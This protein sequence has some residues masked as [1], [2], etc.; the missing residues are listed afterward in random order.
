MTKDQIW[1]RL[2]N[3][4]ELLTIATCEVRG[5]SNIE[6]S[7][8]RLY[9]S[10][11]IEEIKKKNRKE[12]EDSARGISRFPLIR[13]ISES[14]ISDSQT[15]SVGSQIPI[16]SPPTSRRLRRERTSLSHVEAPSVTHSQSDIKKTQLSD[17]LS[18]DIVREILL[19]PVGEQTSIGP[20]TEQGTQDHHPSDRLIRDSLDSINERSPKRRKLDDVTSCNATPSTIDREFLDF[21]SEKFREKLFRVI[22][23]SFTP[24]FSSLPFSQFSTIYGYPPKLSDV[25]IQGIIKSKTTF[26]DEQSPCFHLYSRT[27]FDATCV[28]SL[29]QLPTLASLSSS[30]CLATAT[31]PILE[32]LC[33]QTARRYPNRQWLQ[34]A[35][36]SLRMAC[37]QTAI[38]PPPNGSNINLYRKVLFEQAAKHNADPKGIVPSESTALMY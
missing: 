16:S 28:S 15:T 27:P 9:S 35:R 8:N 24:S 33:Q 25:I 2:S 6:S 26:F 12:L 37:S 3:E 5:T 7:R 32:P 17:C 18:C 1:N 36:N 22:Q 20:K 10:P 29:A 4:S 23:Q 21:P 30:S 19:T 31:C 14:K 11:L 38:T 34:R 13:V